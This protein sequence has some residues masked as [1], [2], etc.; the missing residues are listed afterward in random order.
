MSDKK[1]SIKKSDLPKEL[2][3]C[4]M[5]DIKFAKIGK[6]LD[7]ELSYP[8]PSASICYIEDSAD[9]VLLG[10]S[11]VGLQRNVN[12]FADSLSSFDKEIKNYIKTNYDADSAKKLTPKRFI[13]TSIKSYGLL[14]KSSALAH[15][16]N[17]LVRSENLKYTEV[18][19]EY[20][21]MIFR[22]VFD[23]NKSDIYQV[24]G[25]NYIQLDISDAQFDALAQIWREK[26]LKYGVIDIKQNVVVNPE[27]D[28][29][30]YR[31]VENG[32]IVRKDSLCG[33]IDGKG[34]KLSEIRYTDVGNLSDGLRAVL[35]GDKWGYMDNHGNM[36]IKPTFKNCFGFH[37]GKAWAAKS[38]K[39]GVIDKTGNFVVE[40]KYTPK[41]YY[42]DNHNTGI[43]IFAENRKQ[44]VVDNT[45]R[46]ICEP[47]YEKIYENSDYIELVMPNGKSFI[48]DFDGNIISGPY[49]NILR[50]GS[51]R[52]A[53]KINDLWGVTDFS[54][55]YVINPEY[56]E[57]KGL[58]GAEKYGYL[59]VSK[60]G[61]IGVMDLDGN[62][63]VSPQKCSYLQYANEK[64]LILYKGARNPKVSLI[65][66]N[67]NVIT[68]ETYDGIEMV[69]E[70]LIM[71][72][73]GK[74]Y[75][76]CDFSGNFIIE[77]KYY[78]G[79]V[80]HGIFRAKV[81]DKYVDSDYVIFDAATGEQHPFNRM[82]I[83]SKIEDKGYAIVGLCYDDKKLFGL[84]NKDGETVIEPIYNSIDYLNDEL[85][86]V[87][88]L[89]NMNK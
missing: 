86:Y 63:I 35:V 65:D 80:W 81:E 45:G 14:I 70:N 19:E 38:S 57:I 7:Y 75:G 83:G 67:G 16:L 36:V 22:V 25:D 21:G 55:N 26:E 29:I 42:S 11:G 1:T 73:I 27:Y 82:Y 64:Y 13:A 71:V 53:V 10:V 47:Q 89:P 49:E 61:K 6:K 60:D 87:E 85:I 23:D 2:L 30:E 48:S 56:D 76:I 4:P 46:I 18:D 37:K 54:N 8:Y 51:E 33:V 66:Y 15:G 59:R 17:V 41:M 5:V 50:L 72:K 43:M 9:F 31:D 12:N 40:P 74:Q 52:V 79:D 44:G 69:G 20:D 24:K 28:R 68:K 77:P 62:V 58:L 3:G 32:L 84:I 34:N 78:Y 88:L 39:Y